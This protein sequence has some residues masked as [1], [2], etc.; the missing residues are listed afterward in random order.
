MQL[1]KHN[2]CE[3]PKSAV[4]LL[5]AQDFCITVAHDT[6]LVLGTFRLQPSSYYVSPERPRQPTCR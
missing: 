1:E 2:F 4:Y 5:T 6:P 3:I